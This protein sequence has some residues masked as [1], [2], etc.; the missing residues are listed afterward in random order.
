MIIHTQIQLW[1]L[2]I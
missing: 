2:C 1:K